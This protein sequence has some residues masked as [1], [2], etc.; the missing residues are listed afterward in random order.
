MTLVSDFKIQI[1]WYPPTK[2][3]AAQSVLY[4]VGDHPPLWPSGDGWPPALSGMLRRLTLP[5]L[6]EGQRAIKRRRWLADVCVEEPRDLRLPLAERPAFQRFAMLSAVLA[7]GGCVNDLNAFGPDPLDRAV[8]VSYLLGRARHLP[9]ATATL[10][11]QA[12]GAFFVADKS[13]LGAY[14]M[15][16]LAADARTGLSSLTVDRGVTALAEALPVQTPGLLSYGEL[17][18]AGEP[19]S[20]AAGRSL[21]YRSACTF[22]HGL[23]DAGID[24]GSAAEALL[25][26]GFVN[27]AG[28]RNWRKDLTVAAAKEADHV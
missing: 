10:P 1:E 26:S 25:L 19:A 3:C 22:A 23:I 16:R 24:G 4:S 11:E 12:L 17:L 15:K 6:T 7:G 2:W 20:R 28:H 9:G 18:N 27:R 5:T 13:L 14:G 21:D 8:A